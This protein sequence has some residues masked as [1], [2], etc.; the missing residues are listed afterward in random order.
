MVVLTHRPEFD[1]MDCGAS[2]WDLDQFYMV[3]D[4]LW[5]S[6]VPDRR[7]ML[8]IPCLEARLGCRLRPED[9]LP[10]ELNKHLFSTD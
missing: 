9:F 1:C 10:R 3:H 5:L 2:T 4:E 8:C 6:A 7:G